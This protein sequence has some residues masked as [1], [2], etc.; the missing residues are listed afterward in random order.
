[1]FHRR[2]LPDRR[3]GPVSSW[4]LVESALDQMMTRQIEINFTSMHSSSTSCSLFD[5]FRRDTLQFR[6]GFGF[7]WKADITSASFISSGVW[8]SGTISIGFT[9]SNLFTRTISSLP[10]LWQTIWIPIPLPENK[11]DHIVFSCFKIPTSNIEVTVLFS[12]KILRALLNEHINTL[13]HM[14]STTFF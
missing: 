12:I 3:I 10:T 8:V 1:M 14:L 13:N 11:F 4:S 9:P 2:T 5:P 7:L 6:G